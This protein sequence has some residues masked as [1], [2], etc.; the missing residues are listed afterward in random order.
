MTN[1]A[2]TDQKKIR[3]TFTGIVVSDRMDKTLV[4]RVEGVKIHAKY[5]KRYRVSKK[6]KVHDEKNKYKIGDQVKF[7]EC[8]PLSKD[9]RWRVI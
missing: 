7:I 6:Y 5:R 8:R 1:K 9:K 4:V 2:Q 3:K